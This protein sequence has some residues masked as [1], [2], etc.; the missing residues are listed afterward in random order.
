MITRLIRYY[1]LSKV[2]IKLIFNATFTDNPQNRFF[3]I[4]SKIKSTYSN[5][6]N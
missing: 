6:L 1:L 2:P 4:L 5:Y 3:K